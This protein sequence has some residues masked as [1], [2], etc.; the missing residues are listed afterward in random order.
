MS[1]FY[2]LIVN[3]AAKLRSDVTGSQVFT[4]LR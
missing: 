1:S 3:P 2:G 4:L